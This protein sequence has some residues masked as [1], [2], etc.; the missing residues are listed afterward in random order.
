M[1]LALEGRTIV[2]LASFDSFAKTAM[3][4]LSHCRRHGAKTSLYLV[5]IPGRKLSKRQRAEIQLGDP[6]IKIHRHSWTEIR[7]LC[8]KLPSLCDAIV[9]CLDGQR[10]RELYLALEQA[11][12]ERAA[13]PVLASA[14]PGIL[15][16]YQLEGM[17]DRSGLDL[18]CLNGESDLELYQKGC[19][20]LGMNPNNAIHTGLPILW[21]LQPR[22][23]IPEN[24][25]FVFFEQPSIPAHPLQRRFLCK[26]LQKLAHA[27]PDHQVIFKPRTS[28]L[29]STLHRRHGEME[30]TIRGMKKETGNLDV[31]LQPA[32]KLL[33][34]CGC[35]ITV[36][37]TAALE[38]MA[39]GVSTRIVADLGVNESLGNHY[40][41]GSGAIASFDQIIAD[42]LTVRHDTDWLQRAGWNPHGGDQFI[43]SLRERLTAMQTNSAQ[44]RPGTHGWG[45]EAWRDF[46]LAHGG[47]RML[48]TGGALSSRKKRHH[49][50]RLA[51]RVREKLVGLWGIEEWIKG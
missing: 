45:S 42:P 20:A 14:Y 37:S 34:Q 30:E 15:F 4:M 6:R 21:E 31:S 51:R 33:R 40:F 22:L 36:S 11:A 7:Q 19:T 48:S 41:I 17:L 28:S 35:A 2:A 47:R 32:A 13:I 49:G 5:E 9:L 18:L 50:V 3:A 27:W 46:A 24:S 26:Q 38:S 43:A 12:G 39:M 10:T 29:E 23:E 8:K 25:S 16:R 44:S 1:N